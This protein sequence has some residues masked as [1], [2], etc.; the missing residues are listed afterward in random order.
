[1]AQPPS[2]LDPFELLR[3]LAAWL[4]KGLEQAADRGVRSNVFT[5]AMHKALG[6]SLLAARL[7]KQ[8]QDDL[9]AALNLPTRTDVLALGERLQSL[10]DRIM[11]LSIQLDRLGSSRPSAQVLL[12]LPSPP[13]TRK[14]PA[15][16]PV[17]DAVPVARR[18]SR[19]ARS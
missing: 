13:R 8:L 19:K 12:P 1:M 2:L 4:E 7:R 9:F 10:E 15:A 11:A 14:P 16:P 6:A 5:R 3:G 17:V 18:K